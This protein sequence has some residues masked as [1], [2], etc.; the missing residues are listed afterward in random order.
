MAG[1]RDVTVGARGIAAWRRSIAEYSERRVMLILPLGFASGIPLLLTL[2]TL[3][4]WFA[5]A[6]VSRAAIGAFALVGTPYAFK[7][8]WSPLIDR[9][10][11]PLPLGRRRGWGVTIQLALI[12]ATLALGRCSPKGNLAAM[13]ALALLVA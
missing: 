10:P 12:V 5:T 3:S 13:G 9:L 2:S 7:F 4:A 1:V 11:P 6:G 8:V